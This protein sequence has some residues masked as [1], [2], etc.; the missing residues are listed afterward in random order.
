M[1]SYSF[2]HTIIYILI[3]STNFLSHNNAFTII[4]FPNK[5]LN[6]QSFIRNPKWE[7]KG[8]ARAR[9]KAHENYW[10]NK[11]GRWNEKQNQIRISPNHPC[12]FRKNPLGDN[13]FQHHKVNWSLNSCMWNI[14]TMFIINWEH[15]H[16]NNV[17]SFAC[18]S[19]VVSLTHI[20]RLS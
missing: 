1:Y 14:S 12:V 10:S 8:L 18:L 3:C 20:C 7:T 17:Q 13:Q 9:Q 6:A 5:I 11:V 16:Y 4:D 19:I 15:N 2:A